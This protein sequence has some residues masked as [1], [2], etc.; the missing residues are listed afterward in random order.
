ME[1]SQRTGQ[2]TWAQRSVAWSLAFVTTTFIATSVAVVFTGS[3]TRF[4]TSVVQVAAAPIRMLL[5][6]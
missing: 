5:G 2:I 4:G 1:H 6:L 3:T